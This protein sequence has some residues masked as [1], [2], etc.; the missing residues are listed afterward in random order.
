MA[1]IEALAVAP[2]ARG[3]RLGQQLLQRAEEQLRESGCRLLMADF[4]PSR[5]HLARY[6]AEAGFT[7]LPDIRRRQCT[8]VAAAEVGDGLPDEAPWLGQQTGASAATDGFLPD[9]VEACGVVDRARR[10]GA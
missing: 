7:L 2:A 1:T 8:A 3:I 5:P 4:E 10:R 6:Y 9:P